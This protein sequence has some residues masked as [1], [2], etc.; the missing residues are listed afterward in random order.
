MT[1]WFEYTLRGELE[2][3]VDLLHATEKNSTLPVELEPGH[4]L[5]GLGWI[6]GN[7]HI[8]SLK[9]KRRVKLADTN[10]QQWQQGGNGQGL[11]MC[12]CRLWYIYKPGLSQTAKQC[13][14]ICLSKKAYLILNMESVSAILAF[15]YCFKSR[16]FR[17]P[18]CMQNYAKRCQNFVKIVRY[19]AFTFQWQIP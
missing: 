9:P 14:L 1:C 6:L 13:K 8:W 12:H 18:N 10:L 7:L 2:R 16:E 15:H 17:N 3:W 11:S 4:L 19:Y 5:T